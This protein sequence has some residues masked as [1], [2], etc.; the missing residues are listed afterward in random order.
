MIDTL[1]REDRLRLMKF[2][3][4]F[5]WANLEIREDERRFVAR[6]VETLDLDEDEVAQVE[7]WLEVPPPAE[8]L[9]P[10]EIPRNHRKLFIDAARAM[11]MADGEIDPDE[12]ENLALF[13]MLMK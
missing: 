7:Q 3:C 4:S 1:D 11:V 6:L 2:V 5:A 8:E 9:D 10:A 12:V 13:E